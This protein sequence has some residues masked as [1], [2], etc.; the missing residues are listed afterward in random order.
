MKIYERL[1]QGFI[2]KDYYISFSNNY[3]YLLNYK[4]IVS[5]E[6]KRIIVKFTNFRLFINGYDFK[7]KRKTN[8]EVEITGQ[9]ANMEIEN[10]I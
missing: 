10:E 2:D 8:V 3:I 4:E 1:K 7:I 9:F 6:S 5:F